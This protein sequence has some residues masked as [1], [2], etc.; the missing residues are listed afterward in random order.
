M[1][2]RDIVKKI[3][4]ATLLSMSG[5]LQSLPTNSNK[6]K[7]VEPDDVVEARIQLAT[8]RVKTTKTCP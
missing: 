4:I 7:E 5:V 3:Q 6:P 8:Q 1:S 2:K